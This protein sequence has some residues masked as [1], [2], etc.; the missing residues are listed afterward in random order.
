MPE[1]ILVKSIP[2]GTAPRRYAI[3]IVMIFT[4]AFMD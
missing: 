2:K 4:M 3:T 1:K